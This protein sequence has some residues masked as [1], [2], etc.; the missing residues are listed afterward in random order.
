M[1][2]FAIAFMHVAA[3]RQ[4]GAGGLQ[5]AE[6]M[7]R[8]AQERAWRVMKLL[9]VVPSSLLALT[10]VAALLLHDTVRDVRPMVA[11]VE[12]DGEIVEQ[13]ARPRVVDPSRAIILN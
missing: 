8:A 7:C 10:A 5:K 1:L 13:R 12:V 3:G 9:A 11:V 2:I 4:A 6:R